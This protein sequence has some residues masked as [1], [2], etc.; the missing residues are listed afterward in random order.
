MYGIRLIFVL[1]I[2]FQI[3][4]VIYCRHFYYLQVKMI[5]QILIIEISK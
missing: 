4:K 1:L 5:Q 2:I 3:L